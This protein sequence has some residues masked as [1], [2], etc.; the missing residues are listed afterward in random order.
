MKRCIISFL[1]LPSLFYILD[2]PGYRTNR[3]PVFDQE[4]QAEFCLK[5][6]VF[7][8]DCCRHS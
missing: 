8:S 4:D 1:N 3:W 2:Q 7:V 6:S 5:T